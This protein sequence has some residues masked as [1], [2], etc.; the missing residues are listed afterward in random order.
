[1]RRSDRQTSDAEARE[2][3]TKGEY[4]I[5]STVS[6][7]G[8]P[9]GV[10]VSYV[11][12]N[13]EIVFHSAPE[14]RK[15]DHLTAG[16]PASFCVVGDTEILPSKFSTRY[17]SAIASGTITELVGQPKLAALNSLIEKYSPEFL[18]QGADYV[19]VAADKT[20]VFALQVRTL[21]GKRRR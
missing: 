1:M 9:Y 8:E 10:P 20:R 6:P 12:Q 7:T 19:A 3:L 21:T 16:A 4:G 18:Q 15:I 2:L 17:E 11:F 5:L 13:E 14:G